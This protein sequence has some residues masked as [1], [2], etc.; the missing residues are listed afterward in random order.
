MKKL[1][2]PLIVVT[3]LFSACT[4][5]KNQNK[6]TM[7]NPFY[8]EFTT[9][10]GTPDF[11][12]IKE[13]HFAPAIKKGIEEQNEEIEAIINNAEIA[14]FDNTIAALDYSGALLDKTT[15]V[16]Y[17]L[18][19]A[20]TNDTIQAIARELAP[21]LSAHSDDISMNEKLFKRIKTVYQ[22]K[23]K[24]QLSPEQ[25]TLLEETFKSF[26]RGGANLSEADKEELKKINGEL[27]LL[28]LKFGENQLAE[29]NNYSLVIENEKDLAGLPEAVIN[30]A[31][32]AAKERGMDG[33]WVF[34]LHKPSLIPFIQYADNRDLREKLFK[35]YTMR[36]SN[37]NENDNREVLAKMAALRYQRA[38]L[39]GFENHAA[40]VLDENMAKK[41]EN[42]YH[43]LNELMDAAL[44]MAAEEAEVLQNKINQEGNTF[45]LEP[46]DWW[47]YAEKVRKEKYNL[48]DEA[49]RPY[50]ELE[51]VKNGLFD[52]VHKLYG[53]QIEERTDIPVYQDDVKVYEIKEANGDHI[54]IVFMDFY[55]RPEKGSGAWMDAFR[56]QMKKDGKNISPVIINCF[57]F[58]K[59]AAGKP[60][61]L[62]MDEVTTL[63]HEFGHG[64]HG[65]LS[66]CTYPE[67]SGTSVARDFVELPSQ[68]LENWA[69][70]PEVMKS[71]AKHYE[72]GEVIP[73]KLIN[74]IEESSHFNQGFTM[75]EYLS[76]ALLDMDWHTIESADLQD[77]D[78]FEAASMKKMQ[79]PAEVVVRYRSPYFSHI[80]NGGYSSGY[81]SYVWAEIL[82][83]DA[84]EAFKE[85][86]IFDQKTAKA[87]RENILEKGGSEDPM[88]LYIRFRGKDASLEP[89]LKRKGIIK[90]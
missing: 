47:Y 39:M 86:G 56:K 85:N 79:M 18:L 12:I 1:L 2:L 84:F 59:P 60:A 33:K 89:L 24:L 13:E 76:A 17:N 8:S 67:L 57:N 49:L 54:G 88:Q 74:K 64:L 6:K 25:N 10:F 19:E 32:D 43:R 15:S 75:V 68:I 71:Y 55:T 66:D 27:S 42:V 72:T 37:G 26:V 22:Q 40:F 78:A 58:T 14:D 90:G 28:S 83:A 11:R 63:F 70:Q 48:D 81:Y 16:F 62:N 30:A 82:D 77:A 53:L 5:D 45:K 36:C 69:T 3:L 52:V 73:D 21:I 51:H 29:T 41:P 35:A 38:K 44:P 50:F 9:P 46:W 61:L 4:N 31:V 7:D 65:L 20:N 87:F 23:D 80:F 34:T